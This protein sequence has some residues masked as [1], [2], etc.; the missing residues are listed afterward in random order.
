VTGHMPR[1]ACNVADL[2]K[3]S[4][5]GPVDVRGW[6]D[7][8]VLYALR[9]AVDGLDTS[10]LT[11]STG[12]AADVLAPALERLA[13]AGLIEQPRNKASR[14]WHLISRGAR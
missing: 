12:E 1:S 7:S 4:P 6:P 9:G 8:A 2:P 10:G 5:V 14:T 3:C 13:A 11:R